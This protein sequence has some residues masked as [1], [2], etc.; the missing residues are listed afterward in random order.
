MSDY[1]KRAASDANGAVHPGE[2][3][4]PFKAISTTASDNAVVS[5]VITLTDNTTNLEVAAV[6]ATA[7]VRFVPRTDGAASVVSAAGTAN[8][9]NVVP[10][11]T[12]RKFVVPIETIGTSSIVGANIQN[13][14]YNRVAY[15]T[16]APGSVLTT[17]Y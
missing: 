9:D 13:G 10:A 7:F 15:K 11:G 1:S 6:G 3:P 17:Q 14:L 4:V 5:S 12:V 16:A 8:F 2:T